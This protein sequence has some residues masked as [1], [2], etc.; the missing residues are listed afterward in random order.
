MKHQQRRAFV[1]DIR[2]RSRQPGEQIVVAGKF[3]VGGSWGFFQVH[4]PSLSSGIRA[5][6]NHMSLRGPVLGRQKLGE[7]LYE[8][9]IAGTKIHVLATEVQSP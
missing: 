9:N 3:A 6:A 5:I 7:N 8:V 4:A 1:R 2:E